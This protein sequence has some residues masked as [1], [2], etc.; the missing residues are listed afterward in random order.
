MSL[1]IALPETSNPYGYVLPPSLLIPIA[2]MVILITIVLSESS[3]LS[4]TYL[5][6]PPSSVVTS[7]VNIPEE[8][9]RSCANFSTAFS[10]ASFSFFTALLIRFWVVALVAALCLLA[11]L[12]SEL[13]VIFPPNVAVILLIII[14]YVLPA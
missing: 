13:I 9:A 4:C 1:S 8:V 6:V 10:L 11:V 7:V 14:G 12:E 5:I 3:F 2:F